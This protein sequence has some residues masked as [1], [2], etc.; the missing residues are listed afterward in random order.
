MKNRGFTLVELLVV[1][2]IISLLSSAVITSL[3]SARVNARNTERV[4]QVGEYI[5]AFE[6]FQINRSSYPGGSLGAVRFCL[7]D[8]PANSCYQ[9]I[10]TENEVLNAEVGEY[11][12][13]MPSGNDAGV[14]YTG[15]VY[16]CTQRKGQ[17]CSGFDL[18]WFLEGAEQSC[19]P[20]LR[21]SSNES[22]ATWCQYIQCG[23]GSKP[24]LDGTVY[25]CL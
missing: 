14:P 24:T 2:G 1:T 16:S 4:A 22:G 13:P 25:R 10:A 6:Q 3:S 23:L 17:F 20:G 19:A 5:K 11:I 7:G 15:Y 8:R 21:L 18:I 9:G 12:A